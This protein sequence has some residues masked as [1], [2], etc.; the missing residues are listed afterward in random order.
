[1]RLLNASIKKSGVAGMGW[2]M[3]LEVTSPFGPIKTTQHFDDLGGFLKAVQE[4]AT[5]FAVRNGRIKSKEAND[6]LITKEL[7]ENPE[8]AIR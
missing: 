6:R 1:M 5:F 4:A 2:M 3:E 7:T 8:G